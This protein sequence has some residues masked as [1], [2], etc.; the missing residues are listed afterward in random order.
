MNPPIREAACHLT[1]ASSSVGGGNP[2]TSVGY[3]RVS[4]WQF[5]NRFTVSTMDSPIHCN[6]FLFWGDDQE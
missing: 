3:Q 5:Q 1:T 2:M 4:S 6:N